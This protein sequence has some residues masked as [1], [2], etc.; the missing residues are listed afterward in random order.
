VLDARLQ[1][2][3]LPPSS[4]PKR[5]MS[6]ETT[7]IPKEKHKEINGFEKIIYSPQYKDFSPQLL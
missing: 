5:N 7:G 4:S 2:R 1:K 3:D 6:Q